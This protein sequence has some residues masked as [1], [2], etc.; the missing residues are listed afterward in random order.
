MGGCKYQPKLNQT[1]LKRAEHR[2]RRPLQVIILMGVGD[3]GWGCGWEVGRLGGW[4]AWGAE[5][6]GKTGH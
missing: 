3:E 5:R 1:K 6:E 2:Q 4:A